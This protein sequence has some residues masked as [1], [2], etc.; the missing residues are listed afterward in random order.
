MMA[1]DLQRGLSRTAV[2]RGRPWIL[3]Y[4]HCTDSDSDPVVY[5]C[6]GQ[7]SE[8]VSVS[9]SESVCANV[10]VNEALQNR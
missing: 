7:E 9:L 10:N 3:S 5:F 8:S 4:S 6:K 2:G 1:S